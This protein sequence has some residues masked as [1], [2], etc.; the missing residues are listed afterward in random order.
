[1]AKHLFVKGQ[2]GNPTGRPKGVSLIRTQFDAAIKKIEKQEGKKLFEHFIKTAFSDKHV[3][4]EV[5]KKIIPDISSVKQE[6]SGE[7]GFRL[8]I[9]FP[10]D[11]KKDKAST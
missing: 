2:S 7:G 8:I 4:V 3:L 11:G 1:M 6:I 9:E 5:M 10:N